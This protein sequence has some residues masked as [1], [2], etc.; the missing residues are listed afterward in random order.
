MPARLT[1]IVYILICFE[2]GIL[3]VILPWTAY[4]DDNLFLYFITGKL[5]AAW[6]GNL[7]QSGYV[8]GLVTA[9]GLV[10]IGAGLWEAYRF[11]ESVRALNA[12]DAPQ[13]ATP[14]NKAIDGS[15]SAPTRLPDHRSESVS[16]E[17]GESGEPRE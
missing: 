17:S 4:W 1:V 15:A 5:N 16:S 2:V 6:L 3:L 12:W 8:R 14:D 13:N 7:L 11:K 10:N 9:L